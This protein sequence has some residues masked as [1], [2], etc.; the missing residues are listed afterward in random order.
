MNLIRLTLRVSIWTG[1]CI[2]TSYRITVWI[3]AKINLT[4]QTTAGHQL[5]LFHEE[6]SHHIVQC[7][8]E[9]FYLVG[10]GIALRKRKLEFKA[11]GILERIEIEYLPEARTHSIRWSIEATVCGSSYP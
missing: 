8:I 6:P 3:Q 5:I 11:F 1:E 2:S 9:D 10:L 4:Q 7:F